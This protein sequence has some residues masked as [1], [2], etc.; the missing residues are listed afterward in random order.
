[1][2]HKFASVNGITLHYVEE[3]SG[4][5]VVLL[6]GFPEFWFA[7]RHQIPA[8]AN[9]GFRVVAPDLRGYN[10]SSKPEAIDD[11][12]F[13][14]IIS[15]IA[16]LIEQLGAPCILAGHDWGGLLSWYLAMSRPQLVRKLVV[17]NIPHPAPF[18]R[19]LRRSTS[20]KLRM[21]YQLFFKPPVL[22]E[23]LMRVLLPLIRRHPE[24]RRAWSKPG[25]R[26]GMANYYRAIHR[27]RG[28]LQPLM[29][30]ISVP[31]LL[32]WGEKEPVF[33]RAT[34]EDFDKWVPNLTIARI[35]GAGHF[36]MTDEPELVNEALVRF[37]GT[38]RQGDS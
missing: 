13:T 3:G 17:L 33:T 24:Y 2:E 14:T 1:M 4:P 5:L 8:L 18:L 7:W 11:Y 30:P 32:I 22:P 10:E 23:L 16:A 6:H 12:R 19:E 34:T 36:V 25:A 26:R 28:E 9:A 21:A 31:T 15:D 37:L 20:Q 35:A 38:V 29:A 27:H